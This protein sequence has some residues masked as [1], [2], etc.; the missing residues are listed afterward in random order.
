[1]N[2]SHS[3][4]ATRGSLLFAGACLQWAALGA[5]AAT[6]IWRCGNHYTD[7]PC[8]GGRPLGAD[9]PRTAQQRREADQD[10]RDARAL[11]ERMERERLRLEDSAVGK[12]A[13]LIDDP[14][15]P[16]AA[17]ARPDRS[18]EPSRAKPG[19][20]PKYLSPRDPSAPPGKGK[21]RS[22]KRAD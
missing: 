15:I 2:L 3:R 5:E 6:G 1:M 18:V 17:G 21:G 13:T 19:K 7:R 12:R 9:D 10:T 22:A 11:A 14:R 16:Q 8:E 20:N 4:I